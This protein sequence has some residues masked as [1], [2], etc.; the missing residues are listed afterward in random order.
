MAEAIVTEAREPVKLLENRFGLTEHMQQSWFVTAPDA[1]TI[2][3]IL[4][5]HY[6]TNVAN[7]LR[8]FDEIKVA[9]ESGKFLLILHVAAIAKASA[10]VELLHKY[11]FKAPKEAIESRGANY[12]AKWRGP[13]GKWG[14]LRLSDSTLM[15][16]KFPNEED[17]WAYIAGLN[18][19]LAA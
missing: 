18:Q 16:D 9:S 11:E 2:E 12:V 10:K 4:D 7:K 8:P 13:Y 17:A 19:A 15:R 1:H 6:W 3:D 5:V 14:V